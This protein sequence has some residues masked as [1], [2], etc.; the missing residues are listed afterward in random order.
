MFSDAPHE[1]PDKAIFQAL[2][3]KV[4]ADLL[5]RLNYAAGLIARPHENDAQY[6]TPVQEITWLAEELKVRNLKDLASKIERPNDRLRTVTISHNPRSTSRND[7]RRL[8]SG[9]L[10]S[11]VRDCSKWHSASLAATS[12]GLTDAHERYMAEWPIYYNTDAKLP[13]AYRGFMFHASEAIR[14]VNCDNNE[15]RDLVN[16][17][18]DLLEDIAK[19][20]PHE[21]AQWHLAAH[22]KMQ[23]PRAWD[24]LF[25]GTQIYNPSLPGLLINELLHYTPESGLFIEQDVNLAMARLR[26]APQMSGQPTLPREDRSR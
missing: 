11:A 5:L 21:L 8:L 18:R 14:T 25:T 22:G 4:R 16:R 2:T 26:E 17:T 12:G 9:A 1:S 19:K 10:S 7:A 15:L 23:R 13:H 24:R 20:A 3:P 6:T